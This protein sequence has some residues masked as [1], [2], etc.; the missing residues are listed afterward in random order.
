VFDYIVV[1]ADKGTMLNSDDNQALA[2]ADAVSTSDE[3]QK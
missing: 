2:Q 1:F 3:R